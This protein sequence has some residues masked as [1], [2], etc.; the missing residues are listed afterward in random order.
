M[1]RN[2]LSTSFFS[3]RV[4]IFYP[5]DNPARTEHIQ[6]PQQ[7]QQQQKRERERQRERDKERAKATEKMPS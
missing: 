1:M 4:S 5:K 2:N 7:Q 3:A 6:L